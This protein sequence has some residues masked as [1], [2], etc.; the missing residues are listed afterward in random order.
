MK[1]QKMVSLDAETAQ[2]AAN[3]ENFS[4]FVR[5]VLLNQS[6]R[7]TVMRL[8]EERAL[9]EARKNSI[10]DL[11]STMEGAIYD[12]ATNESRQFAYDRLC[13]KLEEWGRV[14]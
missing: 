11:L 3:M 10:L 13:D 2:I 1:V 6:F 7:E 4:Q 12:L 14:E 9:S 5:D 8:E